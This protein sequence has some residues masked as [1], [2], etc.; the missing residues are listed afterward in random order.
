[1][2][3]RNLESR[4]FYTSLALIACALCTVETAF[5]LLGALGLSMIVEH[6]RVRERWPTGKA[7]GGL[8]L[9]GAGVFL[10]TMLI[11]WPMGLLKLGIA[12]GF[13]TL[14]YFALSREDLHGA[15]SARFMARKG[16]GVTVR[17]CVAGSWTIAAFALWRRFEQRR[18]LLP[19]L[20]YIACFFLVMLKMTL[21]YT[22][23]YAPLVAAFIVV[24]GVVTGSFGSAGRWPDG[25]RWW[26]RWS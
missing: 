23:Y 24:T 18:E 22:Y 26:V 14:I 7:L 9:R 6:R 5:L 1:M 2:F 13:L 19:W 25:P 12:K 15:G 8:I 21:E 3:L 11:C 16:P 20:L 4:W 10:L 17:V